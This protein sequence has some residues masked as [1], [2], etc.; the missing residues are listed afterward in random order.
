MALT[1][2]RAVLR[3]PHVARLLVTS[4]VARLPQGMSSLAILLLVTRHSGYARAGLV[5]GLY[6]AAAGLSNPL[7]SRAADRF[8]ARAVLVPTAICYAA[9]C[10]VLAAVPA[11]AFVAETVVAAATG[12]SSPPV[13]PVVRGL[14]PRILSADDAQSV[15]ALEATAQELV[16]ITGPALVA[17]IAGL[18]SAPVAILA[19]GAFALVGTLACAASPALSAAARPDTGR[20]RGLLRG[21]GL[22]GYVAAGATITVAFTMTDIAVVAFVSGDRAS[23]GSGVVLAVWSLGSMVGGLWFGARSNASGEAAVARSLLAMAA[24]IAVAAAAPG[25]VGLGVLLFLGGMTIAPGLARLYGRVGAAAPAGASTEAFAWIAV[26]LLAG[27]S[28]G[29]VLGGV[30]VESIGPRVTFL[31]GAVPPALA[32]VALGAR[33][34]R[35]HAAGPAEEPVAS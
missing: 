17:L 32:G 18:A 14:W 16:F 4:L 10:A 28:V 33:R 8:G 5:T 26:G 30:S 23:A 12:L 6:V 21:F 24:G 2:Y 9:G 34:R 31:L 20:R 29:A 19:N 25:T 3:A 35:P 27:S 13:V 15:Y 11:D 7:L 22:L 1:R